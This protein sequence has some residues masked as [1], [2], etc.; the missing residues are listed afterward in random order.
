MWFIYGTKIFIFQ[1]HSEQ[2]FDEIAAWLN[3]N[4]SKNLLYLD[5]VHFRLSFIFM[6]DIP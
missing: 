5:F 6:I 4:V 3:E 2:D 1:M